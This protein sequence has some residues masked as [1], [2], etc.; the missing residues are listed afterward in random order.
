MENV[1]ILGFGIPVVTKAA[2]VWYGPSPV[3]R[4]GNAFEEGSIY[5]APSSKK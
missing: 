3:A 4:M 1:L 2:E 5:N